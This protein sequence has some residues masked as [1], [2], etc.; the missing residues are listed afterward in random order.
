[1][2]EFI[3][4]APSEKQVNSSG[5]TITSEDV[6]AA[7]TMPPPMK[8]ARVAYIQY[9]LKITFNSPPC[10]HCEIQ[11]CAKKVSLK[12]NLMMYVHK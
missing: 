4:A 10:P 11:Q 1:M 12:S 2:L 9:F 3:P 5:H 7:A 6:L 8:A